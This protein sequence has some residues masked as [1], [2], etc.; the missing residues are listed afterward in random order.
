MISETMGGGDPM[1][2]WFDQPARASDGNRHPRR[3]ADHEGK[4]IKNRFSAGS[5]LVLTS[6]RRVGV[7]IRPAPLIFSFPTELCPLTHTVPCCPQ[8]RQFSYQIGERTPIRCLT[9]PE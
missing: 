9:F 8:G 1:V 4:D 5:L 2:C 7:P 6:C 3:R